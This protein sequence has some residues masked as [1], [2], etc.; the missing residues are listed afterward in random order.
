VGLTWSVLDAVGAEIVAA[1]ADD[2]LARRVLG[3]VAVWHR[4]PGIRDAYEAARPLAGDVDVLGPAGC[5]A[6]VKRVFARLDGTADDRINAWHGDRRQRYALPRH[7]AVVEVDVF[8]GDPPLCHAID[9]APAL[10]RPGVAMDPADLLL[11]KLQIVRSNS[12]DVVDMAALLAEHPLDQGGDRPGIDL[13]RVAAP[14]ARDWGL[15]HTAATNLATLLHVAPT[16]E[17]MSAAVVLAR[18]TA[19]VEALHDVPKTRRWTLR[20]KVGTRLPW[21]EEVE[22]I[23]R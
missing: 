13:G 18:A 19:L 14:M 3:G 15:F 2:G 7:G 16:I 17:G 1:A 12:K 11:Q 9:F 6:R 20:A 4:T 5:E 10:D 22:D 21:Y 23:E 8:L